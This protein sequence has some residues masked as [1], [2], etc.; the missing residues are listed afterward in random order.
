MRRELQVVLL[1]ACI[2]IC[3]RPQSVHGSEEILGDTQREFLI[4]AGQI[5]YFVFPNYP[6]TDLAYLWSYRTIDITLSEPVS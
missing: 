3:V 1:L 6:L 5:V 2:C 4:H